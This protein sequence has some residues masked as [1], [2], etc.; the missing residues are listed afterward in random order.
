MFQ[1]NDELRRREAESI[2]KL[3]ELSKLLEEATTRNHTE[4]NGDLTDSEKYY[5]LLPKVVE[6][7]SSSKGLRSLRDAYGD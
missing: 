3:E 6:F 7:T 4:E 2:K 1:E 5:D